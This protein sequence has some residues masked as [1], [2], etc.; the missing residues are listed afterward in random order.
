MNN[1]L[2]TPDKIEEKNFRIPLYQRPYAW[3]GA[4]VRQLLEDLR[5]NFKKTPNDHYHIGILSVAKTSDDKSRFDLI[6]GQQRITTLMLIGKAAKSYWKGWETFLTQDRLHL[7]GRKEDQADLLCEIGR[8]RNLKMKAAACAACEVFEKHDDA[9][10]FSKFIYEH[11]AFF[12]AEVPAGYSLMEKNQQFVRM[13]NRGKQLEKHEILKVQLIPR[14]PD[15]S[16]RTNAFAAWN[17]MADCLTGLREKENGKSPENGES[18]KD[19]LDSQVTDDNKEPN[20]GE[21]LYTPIVSIPEFLLIA[22]ARYCREHKKCDVSPNRDKLI[23]T[24]HEKL[25]Q[26]DDP[27]VADSIGAFVDVLKKQ[28]KL[29]EKFF[30][31]ISK[32]GGKDDRYKLGKTT[33]DEEK[34][35]V[36]EDG[37]EGKKRLIVA[38]SFLHVSREPH[39]WLTPAFEWCSEFLEKQVDAEKLISELERIDNT[40]ISVGDRKLELKDMNYWNISHY[41][42]YR[43]DYELWKFYGKKQENNIWSELADDEGVKKLVRDFRFRYC[44]SVEHIIPQHPD[45]ATPGKP[46]DH[47]FGNL[48]LI[49]GSRNSKFS[50]L[51]MEGKKEM[52]LSSQYT[53]SLKMLHFL[54][55]D[56]NSP[57]AG[58]Q[59]HKI[60]L[61]AVKDTSEIPA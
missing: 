20:G 50:N 39:H 12:L 48:A 34:S 52:I 6:D 46:I 7:Y 38:Q 44:G 16:K 35:F 53:E 29:L 17:D 36:F 18:L 37:L 11:A 59:M 22:L 61:E 43:L 15:E 3:E 41:W 14:I 60:L 24:F 57:S 58:E 45:N 40:L 9:Q 23:E 5:E 56:S 21:A 54:W 10:A 32:G 1:A 49:S 33:E 25:L 31:F 51:G 27:T 13:N 55:C 47:S 26:G 2:F 28:V 19:I 4:E 8:E 30:I 42:F